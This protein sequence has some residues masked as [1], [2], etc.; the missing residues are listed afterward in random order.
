MGTC[1]RVIHEKVATV[2][3]RQQK[4]DPEKRKALERIFYGKFQGVGASL[5]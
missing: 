3:E 1:V 5:V 2:A 4:L